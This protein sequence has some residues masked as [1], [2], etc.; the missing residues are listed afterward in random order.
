METGV[1]VAPAV[2]AALLLILLGVLF[3]VAASGRRTARALAAS[4]A[5]VAALNARV[6][7]LSEQME[8]TR[9]VA[10]ASPV[11]PQSAYVITTAGSTGS[12]HAPG[13]EPLA[14][15]VVL[16][17]TVGE[18]LVKLVALGYGVR[19]AL[20]PQTRNRIAFEMRREVRRARKQRKRDLR[21]G[22]R[23]EA[24]QAARAAA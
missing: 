17:A 11:V 18:P 2:G 22:R 5:E 9:L 4:R 10:A 19:R 12:D 6:N 1:W 15:R 24:T 8:L 14:N 23:A 20:A 13:A 7:V 21:A 16:S 3:A